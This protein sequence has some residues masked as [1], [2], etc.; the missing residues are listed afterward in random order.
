MSGRTNISGW[1]I[2]ITKLNAHQ[3]NFMKQ[4]REINP[5]SANTFTNADDFAEKGKDLTFSS[6]MGFTPQNPNKMFSKWCIHT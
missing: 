1:D 3:P 4:I 5:T 6:T 2:D